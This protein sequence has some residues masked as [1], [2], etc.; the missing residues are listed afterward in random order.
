MDDLAILLLSSESYH[1]WN[2]LLGRSWWDHV[3]DRW[4]CEIDWSRV[5]PKMAFSRSG[6]DEPV[7]QNA[8]RPLCFHRRHVARLLAPRIFVCSAYG[9]SSVEQPNRSTSPLH[10][11]HNTWWM[12]NTREKGKEKKR[13]G[14]RMLPWW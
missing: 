5:I 9:S 1:M 4:D 10:C 8:A 7:P 13:D 3:E 2:H 14:R 12:N 11:L 6:M